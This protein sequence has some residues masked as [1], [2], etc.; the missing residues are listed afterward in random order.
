L[1]PIRDKT[2]LRFNVLVNRFGGRPGSTNRRISSGIIHVSKIGSIAGAGAEFGRNLRDRWSEQV[3]L[4]S[5]CQ[6]VAALVGVL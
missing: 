6:S 5:P 2:M 3:S 1:A 4:D